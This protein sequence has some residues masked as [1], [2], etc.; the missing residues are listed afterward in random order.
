MHS[1][2]AIAASKWSNFYFVRYGGFKMR[3]SKKIVNI[4]TVFILLFS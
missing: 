2:A 3:K 4:N 1:N